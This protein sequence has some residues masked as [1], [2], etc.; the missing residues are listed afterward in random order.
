MEKIKIAIL[1]NN[2]KNDRNIEFRNCIFSLSED[3]I[4]E[5]SLQIIIQIYKA[6]K[7]SEIRNKCLNL[8]YNK[9]YE[10]LLDFFKEVFVKERYLDMRLKAIRGLA[11]FETEIEVMK[12]MKKFNSIL[13]KR[14]INTPYNYQ[15]YELLKGKNALPFLVRKYNYDCFKESLDIVNRNYDKMPDAFKGHFTVNEEGEVVL[16]KSPEESKRILSSFW[17]NKTRQ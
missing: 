10:Q 15:E 12:Y 14:P 16:L 6:S 5:S 2:I 9:K 8:L 7:L 1:E 4:D 17:E 13:E 3:E 11:Q